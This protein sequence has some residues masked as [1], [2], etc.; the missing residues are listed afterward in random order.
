MQPTPPKQSF[1]YHP[2][3]DDL[4]PLE[5][6]EFA[7]I[8]VLDAAIGAIYRD[9]SQVRALWEGS[10]ELPQ[11]LYWFDD[12]DSPLVLQVAAGSQ[13]Q[14]AAAVDTALLTPEH[15]L[16]QAYGW[17]LHYWA[18]ASDV[19]EPLFAHN[20]P[21]IT[22][23]S[24]RD[25]SIRSRRYVK[26]RWNY[27][28]HVD[29]RSEQYIENKLLIPPEIDGPMSWVCG[30]VSDVER[31]SATLTRSKLLGS[32]AD[33]LY[34]FRATHTTFR[35]YQFKPIL[36]LLET[37]KARLLVADE[38][39]LGKTIEA[40]LLWTEL[41]ARSEADRTLIICPSSLL[42]KWR[43][44][45]YDRFGFELIELDSRGLEDFANKH[46]AGRLPRRQ[47]YI[48]SLERLRTW[49]GLEDLTETPPEFDLVI[50]DEAHAMRNSDTKSFKLG[51]H[52]AEWSDALV[53][54]TAT[55][56]NLRQADLL[57]LLDLLVPEDF[58]DLDDLLARLEPNA[59]LNTLRTELQDRSLT[60]ADRADTF[61]RLAQSAHGAV[62]CLRPEYSELRAIITRRVLTPTDVAAARRLIAQLNTLS[63]VITRTKK[64]DVDEAKAIRTLVPST[65][66][67]NAEERAFYNEY[68]AWC[69]KRAELAGQA[70]YFAMQMPLRLASASLQVARQAVLASLDAPDSDYDGDGTV[71]EAKRPPRLQPHPELLAA[72]YALKPDVDSKF[73]AL[74][75]ALMKLKAEGRKAILFTFSRPT[76]AYLA[77]HLSHQLRVAVMHGGVDRKVRRDIMRDFR[78]DKYD[79]V[80]ANRV[81]SEGLDFE[82]C[83]AIVNYDLPWNPMEIEQRIGRI[84]RIG[85]VEEKML[86]LNFVSPETI[87][88]RILERV[89]E[90]IKI[91]ESSIG[92]LE[93]I[94]N[95]EMTVLQQAFDFTLSA[96]ERN[97]K[98]DQALAAIEEKKAGL[99]D[100]SDASA[101]LLVGNDLDV[102]GL[103]DQLVRTGRYVGQQ[104]LARLIADWSASAGGD[105]PV[106]SEDR[107]LMMLRGNAQMAEHVQALA[108]DGRRG[109]SEV[110]PHVRALREESPISLVLD[111][112]SARKGAG[113]L[114]SSNH[115]LV[116]AAASM[117]AHRNARF[118]STTFRATEPTTPLG[119]FVVLL[120]VARSASDG[121]DEI[122]GSAVDL[123]GRPA[124]EGV[125]DALLGAL[126][127]ADLQS[128]PIREFNS[129]LVRCAQNAMDL[130]SERQAAEQDL[131]DQRASALAASRDVVIRE[132]HQRKIAALDRRIATTRERERSTAGIRLFEAQK[133]RAEERLSR[134]LAKIKSSV[135]SEIGLDHTAVCVVE[136]TN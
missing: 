81:A 66:E 14:D 95:D 111:Q 75:P 131:R 132:Q 84:D 64:S 52:I 76:L 33:T 103:E 67:W 30:D 56:I 129:T 63:M 133:A 134:N 71:L 105:K 45:M 65:V 99:Q 25:V 53:F 15:P 31:F 127:R 57:N 112:E 86:I 68:L 51:Q 69:R 48:C 89:L 23:E 60:A 109:S 49:K 12:L 96:E 128:R 22:Q 83:S 104:E 34:S 135:R 116:M 121:G 136:V 77:E 11:G 27:I 108:N 94:I 115:P 70:M 107:R 54:L 47:A 126:A 2:L 85:Q 90:R 16:M 87:D 106:I 125:S 59:V 114:L 40:G 19:P 17:A 18:R 58:T 79:I 28:V 35:P 39:G 119:V 88:E 5:G 98:A 42:G 101:A 6:K 32:Y 97:L 44:E 37:G 122:W 10:A 91:F 1:G 124:P 29:G 20:A 82:F 50:V 9:G 120:A 80:L 26:G 46:I 24:G 93:P 41:E 102:S 7:R 117:P 62:L 113:G 21:A 36:K 100:V 130:L 13:T 61:G 73:A 3:F 78:D 55:P 8:L 74:R 43:D 92:A 123:D 110:Q 118:T 38:V 72:A 4:S